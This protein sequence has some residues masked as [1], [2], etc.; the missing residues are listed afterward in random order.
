MDN[1]RWER[2]LD[3]YLDFVSNPLEMIDTVKRKWGT[4]LSAVLTPFAF[5]LF[6]AV[7]LLTSPW[8]L[9][10]VLARIWERR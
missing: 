8:G 9:F 6:I 4:L 1:N 2:K 10:L 3:R 7:A 5:V